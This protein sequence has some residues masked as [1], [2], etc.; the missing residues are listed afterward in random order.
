[1][2]WMTEIKQELSRNFARENTT[3]F[4][5][6]L[7]CVC[8]CGLFVT[9][10]V[11]R[12]FLFLTPRCKTHHGGNHS[13]TCTYTHT[14]TNLFTQTYPSSTAAT[15]QMWQA[16]LNF[17][18]PRLSPSL[19]HFSSPPSCSYLLPLHNGIDWRLSH[20]TVIKRLIF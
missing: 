18:A 6:N 8:V 5:R 1:M 20:Q 19:M 16:G 13:P 3:A 10:S 11:S 17:L 9:S 2:G 14:H 15:Q 12:V 7:V 4:C